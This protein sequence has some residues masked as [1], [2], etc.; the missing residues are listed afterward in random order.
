MTKASMGR[1]VGSTTRHQKDKPLAP[2][3]LAAS[4][5]SAGQALSAPINNR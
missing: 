4:R 5:T 3:I 1:M 2:S